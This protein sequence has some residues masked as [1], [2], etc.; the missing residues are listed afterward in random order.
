MTPDTTRGTDLGEFRNGEG[1]RYE[2]R[3][4]LRDTQVVEE[5]RH[6]STCPRQVVPTAVLY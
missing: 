2:A 1:A 5:G 6:R 4:C 3:V